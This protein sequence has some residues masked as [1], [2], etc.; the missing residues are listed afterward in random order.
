M[1]SVI[2]SGITKRV[3]FIYYIIAYTFPDRKVKC[4]E[5]R[6]EK[7]AISVTRRHMN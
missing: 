3:N 4:T 2:F 7:Y 1:T 5:M 6:R